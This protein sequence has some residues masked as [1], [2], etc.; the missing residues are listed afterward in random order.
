M[1]FCA[2]KSDDTVFISEE[3][4]MSLLRVREKQPL[5]ADFK[6]QWKT[7][8][9]CFKIAFYGLSSFNVTFTGKNGRR[10]QAKE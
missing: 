8:M 2:L 5:G 1:T 7:K 3:P 4:P 10:P 6:R 9:N